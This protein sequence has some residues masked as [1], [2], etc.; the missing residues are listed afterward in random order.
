MANLAKGR[1]DRVLSLFFE[2]I[3]DSAARTATASAWSDNHILDLRLIWG[4]QV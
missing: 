4:I 1:L 3:E 2:A